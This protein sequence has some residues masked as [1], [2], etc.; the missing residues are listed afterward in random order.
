MRTLY[1]H[2]FAAVALVVALLI[3]AVAQ[4]AEAGGGTEVSIGGALAGIATLILSVAVPLA[5]RAIGELG[6]WVGL[7]RGGEA[8]GQLKEYVERGMDV[9]ERQAEQRLRDS[10]LTVDVHSEIAAKAFGY[11]SNQAPGLLKDAGVT[12]DQLRTWVGEMVTDRNQGQP[13]QGG[14]GSGG[15]AASA[16]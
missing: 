10:G 13:G 5:K 1:S 6:S 3:P 4:A 11:V 2:L 15:Q 12:E 7:K 14:S 9:A 16:G 8:M